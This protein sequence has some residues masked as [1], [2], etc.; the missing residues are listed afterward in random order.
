M[1]HRQRLAQA[2]VAL[3]GLIAAAISY[4]HIRHLARAHA[5]TG[6]AAYAIPLTIDGIEIIAT[7]ALLNHPHQRSSARLAWTMLITATL[8]SIAANIAAAP[9]DPIARAIA[10]WPAAAFAAAIKLLTTLLDPP[11]APAATAM[12]EPPTGTP[13]LPKTDSARARWNSI[14]ND[15]LTTGDGATELAARHRITSRQV[16]AIL[17]A[18]NAGKL[19]P[20]S[21]TSSQSLLNDEVRSGA[22]DG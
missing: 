2:T 20:S 9:T 18:G 21:P 10:A 12:E 7:L 6:W 13:R 16:R 17:A 8:A 11:Q 3:L 4:D 15:H 22:A 19:D 1:K 14:W 5:E